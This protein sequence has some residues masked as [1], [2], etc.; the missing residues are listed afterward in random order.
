MLTLRY[1]IPFD[2][3]PSLPE[4]EGHEDRE[5]EN[6]RTELIGDVVRLLVVNG[7]RIEKGL[8]ECVMGSVQD[9][10]GP[11]AARLEAQPGPDKGEKRQHDRQQ[12]EIKPDRS[13]AFVVREEHDWVMPKG[14]NE[15]GNGS[16]SGKAPLL[17]EFR[18]EKTPPPDLFTDDSGSIANDSERCGEKEV[19]GNAEPIRQGAEAER[20]RDLSN[21]F[22]IEESAEAVSQT[23]P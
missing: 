1:A 3:A 10:A 22:L 21:E 13:I 6:A 19:Q 9:H 14:P 2:L 11:D 15:P 5:D 16:S 17:C 7:E 4:V 23:K 12:R 8:N 18:N 20:L